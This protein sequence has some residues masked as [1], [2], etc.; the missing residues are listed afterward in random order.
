MSG[1]QIY[2]SALL[3][4]EMASVFFLIYYIHLLSSHHSSSLLALM[5]FF[6]VDTG[7][8]GR[9][10]CLFPFSWVQDMYC[11]CLWRAFS[12]EDEHG[13][14]GRLDFSVQCLHSP[15]FLFSEVKFCSTRFRS[16]TSWN[17]MA[18]QITENDLLCQPLQTETVENE[19]FSGKEKPTENVVHKHACRAYQYLTHSG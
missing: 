11:L 18:T 12:V 2:L 8:R 10:L 3:F 14:Q 15:W 4:S 16:R 19:V 7:Y 17:E 1:K 13:F 6:A 9:R 5:L